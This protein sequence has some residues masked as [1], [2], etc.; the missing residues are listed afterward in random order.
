MPTNIRSKTNQNPNKVIFRTSS[1]E[2][3]EKRAE[4]YWKLKIK[5]ERIKEARELYLKDKVKN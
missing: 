5:Q 1:K 3:L 2:E 4:I